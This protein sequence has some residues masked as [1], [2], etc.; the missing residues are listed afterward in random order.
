MSPIQQILCILDYV[1]ENNELLTLILSKLN[2]LL[3]K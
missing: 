1:K 3:N 2:T